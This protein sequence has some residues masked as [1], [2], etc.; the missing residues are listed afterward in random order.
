MK[1]LRAIN[2]EKYIRKCILML[3]LQILKDQ[4]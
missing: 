1:K 4:L 3:H 2:L